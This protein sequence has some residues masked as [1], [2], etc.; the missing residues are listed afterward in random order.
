MFQIVLRG[1]TSGQVGF[2]TGGTPGVPSGH[3]KKH[4]RAE[5]KDTQASS[6]QLGGNPVAPLA[7]VLVCWYILWDAIGVWEGI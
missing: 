4:H 2:T 1:L 5:L 3:P 7:Q 6:G